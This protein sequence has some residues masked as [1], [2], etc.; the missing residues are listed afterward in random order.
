[1]PCRLQSH[2]R[3]PPLPIRNCLPVSCSAHPA[4]SAPHSNRTARTQHPMLA[5]IMVHPPGHRLSRPRTEY[6]IRMM[7]IRSGGDG[8]DVSCDLPDGAPFL[9]AAHAGIAQTEDGSPE[10]RT[11]LA[12]VEDPI[13]LPTRRPLSVRF[14]RAANA[15]S[16]SLFRTYRI[17]IS[18]PRGGRHVRGLFCARGITSP[19]T[20][21][22]TR[23]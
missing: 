14:Q 5:H 7:C 11:E 18:G 4:G 3:P 16:A 6:E 10:G 9:F 19:Q 20:R 2:R 17:P 13:A 21:P 15:W 23:P 22:T 1:M 12:V 8:N